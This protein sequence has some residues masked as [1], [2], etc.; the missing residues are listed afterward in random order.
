MKSLLLPIKK[1]LP[2]IYRIIDVFLLSA[3]ALY[4][5]Y[6]FFT[7]EKLS[8]VFRN[9]DGPAYVVVAKTLY[10]INLINAI[11]PFPYLTPA[12]YS[13]QFPLYPVFIRLFSFVGY[14]ESMIVVSQLFSLLFTIALY[15]LVK[16]VN[17][18]ANALVV[19][20]LSL[21]YTPR[22]FIVNHVGSTEPQFLFFITL[23]MLFFINKKFLWSGA[24]AALAQLT[25]PQGI[26][27]FIGITLYYVS[28]VGLRKISL[29][30]S[31]KE[32]T[33][34]LLIPLALCAIFIL[35]YFRYGD[36]FIFMKNEAF[37]TMQW[38]PLKVLTATHIFY[39][40]V[41]LFTGW[42]EIVVYNYILYFIPILI[43]FEKKLHFFSLV[44]LIYFLP[45]LLFV[46]IDMAR[47]ILPIMP[48]A[49]LAYSDMLSKKPVYIGLFLCL[50]MVFLFAVGYINYNLAPIPFQ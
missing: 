15:L 20:I 8:F 23:F 13:Y 16:R 30:Q 18:K 4:G 1:Y 36:F 28:M 12:H 27:F 40:I 46:Q 42:K 37:P 44:M 17:P 24:A 32:F 19:A 34:Y 2:D 29:K 41:D 39:T 50:P 43:L 14:P 47:F 22:W 26:I 21:F 33:P 31:I 45:V 25:K 6:E 11:N 38:P 10:N 5:Y 49:F 7:P 35:Y 3:V 48:F 9:W